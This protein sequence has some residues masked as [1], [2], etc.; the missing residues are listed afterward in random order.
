M[1]AIL[2]N[3]HNYDAHLHLECPKLINYQIP[4]LF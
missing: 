4:M 2:K 1:V 3:H